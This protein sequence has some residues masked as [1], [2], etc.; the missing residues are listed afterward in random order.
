MI[1]LV[2]VLPAV[3]LLAVAQACASHPDSKAVGMAGEPS[4]PPAAT[5]AQPTTASPAAQSAAASET[6]ASAPSTSAGAAATHT[7]VVLNDTTLTNEEVKQIIAM[8]YRPI[9]RDAK[10][11]YCR[12]DSATGSHLPSLSC[13]TGEQ[14]K[15]IM[16]DSQDFLSAKQKSSGCRANGPSC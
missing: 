16:R 9:E 12:R 4:V 15:Q 7:R 1:R 8:G 13:R 10:I 11:W 6:S 3:C 5:A 14:L 2:G